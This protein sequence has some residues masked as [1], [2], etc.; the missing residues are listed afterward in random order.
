MTPYY[1]AN[2]I[3]LYNM[4]CLEY[5]KTIPD[6][7]IELVVTSPPY[8]NIRDYQGN[9]FN[10]ETFQPIAA[11]LARILCI[12]GV[13]VWNVADATLDGSES[14]TSLRQALYFM[15]LKL[16]LHDTMIYC[17]NNPIPAS[18][19]NKRYHQA[20]EYIFVFS[21]GTPN[22]FNPLQVK[23]KYSHVQNK[24]RYRGA[25]NDS[26]YVPIK[27]NEYTKVRNV[28]EYSIGGGHTTTDKVAYN[29]PALMPEQLAADMIYTWSNP[30]ETVF[31]PFSGAGTTAK[32][33]LQLDRKFIGA[34]ISP[35][36]CEITKT[37]L[38]VPPALY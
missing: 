14:G 10:F 13:I 19:S 18:A 11:E 24:G 23:A 27:R 32:M 1:A 26:K 35:E 7:S 31:D 30:G 29:H 36:Y 34:E 17:K 8:D 21:K 28:F 3:E 2:N 9:N 15:E 16:R 5:A 38:S 22:T 4:D 20:W 37:R 33:C 25:K 6:D 12:G